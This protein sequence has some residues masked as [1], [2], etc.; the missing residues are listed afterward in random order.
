MYFRVEL[1]ISSTD[2][3]T[4]VY[5]IEIYQELLVEFSCDLYKTLYNL[6]LLNN[7]LTI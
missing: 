2:Y 7:P 1:F 4:I 5:S 6:R 3:V